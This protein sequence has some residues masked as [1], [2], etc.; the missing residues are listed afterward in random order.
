MMASTERLQTDSQDVS[1]SLSQQIDGETQDVELETPAEDVFR[2][3]SIH[4]RDLLAGDSYSHFS[5]IPKSVQQDMSRECVLGID[6]AG[7]GPVLGPMVYGIAYCPASYKD[8]LEEMGFDGEHRWATHG[9][10][11]SR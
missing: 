5:P 2:A 7:R 4:E 6:E 3:P 1:A 9:I 10:L 8:K 11:R